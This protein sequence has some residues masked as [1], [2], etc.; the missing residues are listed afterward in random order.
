LL[1]RITVEHEAVRRAMDAI[2]TGG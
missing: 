2:R 1:A